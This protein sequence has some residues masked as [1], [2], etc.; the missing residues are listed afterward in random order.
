MCL[1]QSCL[2]AGE[3][4]EKQT[5]RVSIRSLDT[6]TQSRSI[7]SSLKGEFPL[8]RILTICVTMLACA[9]ELQAHH[10]GS[11]YRTT[12]V[13]IAGTVVGFDDINPHTLT[14]LE[15]RMEDGTVRRWR[16]EGPGRSQL[17]GNGGGQ[18]VPGV[19]DFIEV[20]GFP[21]RS[22]EE[23]SRMFPEAGF[24]AS[25][26]FADP[27][28]AQQTVA[29]HILVMSDGAL[30]LWEPHGLISECIR[31]SGRPTESWLGFLRN[32]SRALRGW[33]EQRRYAHV[34]E[35]ASL[36]E[37]IETIDRPLDGPC[38]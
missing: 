9:A 26:T 27:G 19:G 13:W 31:S 17:A 35:T 38:G 15:E 8:M 24:A 34:E 23:L 6:L 28:V 12:P 1:D 7:G 32:D 2:Q 3:V 33:C 37:F 22:V 16:V 11:M 36:R 5:G 14:M 21:Y 4:R 18:V 29:G 25:Q 20:C 30:Q 10:T